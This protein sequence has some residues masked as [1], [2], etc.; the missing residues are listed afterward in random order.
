MGQADRRH[1]MH[2]MP[3]LMDEENSSGRTDRLTD[4]TSDAS[5][6][7]ALPLCWMSAVCMGPV[8]RSEHSSETAS[9][10]GK[11]V[12][13]LQNETVF[14][15]AKEKR[16]TTRV[17]DLKRTPV[18]TLIQDK[19]ST[20]L[21]MSPKSFLSIKRRRYRQPSRQSHSIAMRRDA[22]SR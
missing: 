4:E 17:F 15:S 20:H 19:L 1:R 12:T 3:S 2:L 11:D 10:E 13:C 18:L 14:L 8:R 22:F 21:K 9:G 16:T 7:G 5:S 6:H